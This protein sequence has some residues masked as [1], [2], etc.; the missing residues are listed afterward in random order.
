MSTATPETFRP[1]E[2]NKR[3]LDRATKGGV[4][5]SWVINKALNEWL[6]KNGYARKKDLTC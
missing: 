3:M 6:K 1:S 5:K 2:S 4:S